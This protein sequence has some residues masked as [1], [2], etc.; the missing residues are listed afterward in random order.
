MWT[1]LFDLHSHST[2]SD[3][4][5]SVDEVA[6]MM[7]DSNV[8]F[9]SLT[10]HDTISGWKDAK[11]AAETKG[12]VFIPGVELTCMPGLKA[13]EQVM[14]LHQRERASDSW[15]LLAYF[16]DID[17]QSEQYQRFKTWLAP[18]GEGRI[19]RMVTMVENLCELGMPIDLD[20]VLARAGD[21]VGRPHL[22]DEMV[23]QG[24]VET[25]QE[26]FDKWIG[27]GKPVHIT[28]KKPSIVESCEAVHAA[29]GITSLAHPLYYCVDTDDLVRFCLESGVDA[30]ECFHRSHHDSYRYQL[31]SAA[32]QS[33]LGS[34]CGSDFHGMMYN[35]SPGRMAV[36]TTT[37]PQAFKNALQ[38]LDA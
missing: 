31:W 7:A 2:N 32:K 34:T 5:H 17:F 1:E 29:G 22:A 36:P 21:S 24:Y 16:P 12:L 9:W 11:Y 25:R 14:K 23:K 3:G 4:Q 10:D 8:R 15:H 27:D 33:S 19:P 30:I 28:R 13:N 6:Q 18:L 38:A 37:L 26:A 35:Q 20:A